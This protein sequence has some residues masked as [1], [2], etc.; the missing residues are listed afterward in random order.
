[1]SVQDEINVLVA[2]G[3]LFR[4]KP[5][6]QLQ[7]EYRAMYVSAQIHGLISGTNCRDEEDKFRWRST[8]ADLDWFVQG[9]VI[10]VPVESRQG[11]DHFMSQLQPPD[12]EVWDI[13]CRDP[14]PGIRVLGS[15]GDKDLFIALT[16]EL[17]N[18][19]GEFGSIAWQEATNRSKAEWQRLFRSIPFRGRYPDAYITGAIPIGDD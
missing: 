5:E 13:R 10:T 18:P 17:R 15:F 1:M 14:V 2:R 9:R 19:L 3:E 11:G 4:L 16:W 12:D 7:Q 8:R 6:Y